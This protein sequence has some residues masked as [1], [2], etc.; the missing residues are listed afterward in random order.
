VAHK[1]GY[2]FG[3]MSPL[4]AEQRRICTRCG[5]ELDRASPKKTS[6]LLDVLGELVDFVNESSLTINVDANEVRNAVFLLRENGRA[7]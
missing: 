3:R 4:E 7:K 1:I 6:E 5:L 2:G